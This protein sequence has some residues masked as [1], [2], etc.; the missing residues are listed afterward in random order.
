MSKTKLDTS[1]VS[2][3]DSNG[4]P[5]LQLS[6][7]TMRVLLYL[8]L[9]VCDIT[10]IR[11]GFSIGVKLK[12]LRWLSPNGVELGWLILAVYLPIGLRGGAFA[13][14]AVISRF[15]SARKAVSALIIAASLICMLIFFQYAGQL[16]SR[17][18]FGISI[19]L[20]VGFLALFR[21]LF[22]SIFVQRGGKWV[23]GELLI[24]DG[25][26]APD[27]F[28]GDILFADREG[29]EP[30]SQNPKQFDRLAERVVR[31]DRVVV[32]C[33]NNERRHRWGQMMKAFDVT[34]EVLLDE[35]SPLGAIGIDRFMGRDTVVV[36]RG[37]LSLG[38][39]GIKRARIWLF[40]RRCCCSCCHC[41]SWWRLRSSWTA[42]G[43][44]CSSNR[45]WD[46]I[47]DNS[48]STNS[49]RCGG[50]DRT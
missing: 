17:L 13:F 28:T 47:T 40:Q 35:G 49:V 19:L 6:R 29:I 36:T 21:F 44:C 8:A 20:S 32:A 31:Y 11:A 7:K 22:L 4:T 38:K 23:L 1:F 45:G 9:T 3:S 12:G 50:S 14:G 34:A 33:D 27:G 16:V 42:R 5:R 15:D 10:A 26:P 24:L 41:C 2:P 39:R 46:A 43:L 48:R 37:P 18:A 30:D 25:V